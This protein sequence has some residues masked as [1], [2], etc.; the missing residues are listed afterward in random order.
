MQVENDWINLVK[1][2]VVEVIIEISHVGYLVVIDGVVLP[3]SISKATGTLD[4]RFEL[5]LTVLC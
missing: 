5:I 1:G 4:F 3:N 2:M